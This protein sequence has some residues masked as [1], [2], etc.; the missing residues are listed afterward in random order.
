MTLNKRY[1]LG[2]HRNVVLDRLYG[3]KPRAIAEAKGLNVERVRRWLRRYGYSLLG[4]WVLSGDG[5]RE[6][7]ITADDA[8]HYGA[9]VFPTGSIASRDVSRKNFL[10]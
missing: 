7:W 1:M 9:T 5:A 2:R 10:P 3:L 4:G 8:R 6:L